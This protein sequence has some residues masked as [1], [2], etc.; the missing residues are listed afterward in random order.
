MERIIFHV[1]MDAFYAAVEQQDNPSL[2]E[3]PVIIGARPGTRGVVSA[4][5]YEARKF[6]VH[7]AMPISEAYRRCPQGVYLPVRM[8]RYQEISSRIMELFGNYT[9]VVRQISVDEAFLDMTGTER[10]F[11]PPKE[12]AMRMKADIREQT[13]CTLSIGAAANYYIA[14]LASEYDK[15]DGLYIVRPGEEIDFLDTLQLKNLWGIG[16]KTLSRMEELNI[17]SI[18]KLR[19]FSKGLLESMFGKAA[20][21]YLYRAVRGENPGV[22]EEEPKSRSVSNEITF[23]TDTSDRDAVLRVLLEL[24]HQVMF[25]VMKHGFVSSTVNLKIRF[26]DFTTTS[27]QKTFRHHIHSAEEMYA[28]AREL[29]AKRWNGSAPLR[30]IGVGLGNVETEDSAVQG[31][32]FEDRQEKQKRVEKTVFELT[33]KLPREAV[34]VKAHLLGRKPRGKTD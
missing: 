14:K 8:S 26:A 20:G 7:S 1:D 9:P 29:L 34:V 3:K 21:E 33:K 31:E 5:S 2:R 6:G 19:S 4:C 25:R 18:P 16:K 10:L 28:I 13:G 24:S 12:A 11:G 27:I 23:P 30:L 22:F 17:T 32:L 15:P